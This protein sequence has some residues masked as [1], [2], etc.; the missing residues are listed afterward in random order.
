MTCAVS[1]NRPE[2]ICLADLFWKRLFEIPSYQRAYSWTDK[3]RTDLFDDIKRSFA[4]TSKTHFMNTIIGLKK[5]TREIIADEH[6]VID[7]VD[8]QQRITTLTILYKAISKELNH[9]DKKDEKKLKKYIDEMLVKPTKDQTPLLQTNHD[10]SNYFTEYIRRGTIPNKA[11]V[12]TVAD[13]NLTHAMSECEWFVKQWR[14]NGGNM[15]ELASH[16][17]NN[18]TFIYDQM[19]DEALI[20]S[21]FEVLN[22]RGVAASPLDQLKTQLMGKLHKE[23]CGERTLKE[24]RANWSEIYRSLNSAYARPNGD[25]VILRF[26][27]TLYEYHKGK[28]PDNKKSVSTLMNVADKCNGIVEVTTTIKEVAKI[29]K[30]LSED[31]RRAAV[32]K[33]IQSRLVST[34]INLRADVSDADRKYL[35]GRLDNLT[36][37]IHCIYRREAKTETGRYVRLAHDIYKNRIPPDDIRN[38][39]A[40]IE[41]QYPFDQA[42]ID[43]LSKAIWYPKRKIEILY[44]LF[45]YEEHLAAK[46]NLSISQEAWN[47]IWNERLPRTIEHIS[48]QSAGQPYS[49]WLGNLLVLPP[50]ENARVRASR[51]EDKA[52]AYNRSGLL[53]AREVAERLK[54][55]DET[56]VLERGRRILSWLRNEMTY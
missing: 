52:D 33:S 2:L 56:A 48:P 27:A 35:L 3:H 47:R 41:G 38:R 20:Y 19:Y 49:H 39:L 8:G 25:S 55:W 16:L 11:K 44:I 28:L 37:R 17:N 9:S 15:I 13:T 51:P 24:I 54:E 4:E 18:L 5:G 23:K 10:T 14:S 6:A 22:S 21:V 40:A 32:T 36:L 26:V 31:Y 43:E 7:I 29:T 50:G 53:I 46:D 34:A 42:K 30:S 1:L 12:S 45:K